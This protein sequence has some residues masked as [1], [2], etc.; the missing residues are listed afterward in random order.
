M[1][2]RIIRDTQNL[3]TFIKI[4]QTEKKIKSMI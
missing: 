2:P 1:R 3:Y 4:V